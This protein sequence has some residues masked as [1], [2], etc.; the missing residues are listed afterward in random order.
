MRK[1]RRRAEE[2]S[3]CEDPAPTVDIG[4]EIVAGYAAPTIVYAHIGI[5]GSGE[6][7]DNDAAR[8]IATSSGK[9]GN[10]I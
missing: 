3:R 6:W 9:R 10:R 1:A 8:R 4:G 7:A 2:S 5:N